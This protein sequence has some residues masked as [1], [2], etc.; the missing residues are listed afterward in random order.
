MTGVTT[1]NAALCVVLLP[2]PALVPGPSAFAPAPTGQRQ[3]D[4]DHVLKES[5]ASL[6]AAYFAQGPYQAWKAKSNVRMLDRELKK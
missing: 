6:H 3:S 5:I 4:A 1:L 2:G